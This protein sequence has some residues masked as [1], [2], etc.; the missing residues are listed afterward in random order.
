MPKIT[1]TQKST[2]NISVSNEK[3]VKLVK[4]FLKLI[5]QIKHNLT[6]PIN[7]KQR[8]VDSIRLKKIQ[9]LVQ[10][11]KK[12]PDPIKSGEQISHLKGVGKGSVTRINEILNTGKLSEIKIDRTDKKMLKEIEDLKSIH[13]I[14][15]NTAVYLIKNYDIHSVSELK[16]KYKQGKVPLNEQILLGLKY[17]KVYKK[18]IPREEIDQINEYFKNVIKHF[19]VKLEFVICGSYRR[20]K[21]ESKDIDVLLFNKNIITEKQLLSEPNYL[22]TFVNKLKKDKFIVQDIDPGYSLMY[23]GFCR[24]PGKDIRHI[25]IIYAPY[26]SYASA[27]MHFTG[28]GSFNE[29]LRRHAKLLGYKLNQYG[30]Y[31]KIKL[32]NKEERLVFVK[33]KTEKEIFDLLGMEYVEPKDRI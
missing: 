31:K 2:D 4:E 25:D 15:E 1:H 11:I 7:R 16:K 5:E 6:Q 33:T 12:Y 13:G 24:L 19:D 17:S 29:K 8:F 9:E 3:N 26:E 28:S 18:T 14:G 23:M 30:L 22:H 21:K 27:L 32:S 10:I 20:E